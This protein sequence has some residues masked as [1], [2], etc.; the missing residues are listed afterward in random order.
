MLVIDKYYIYSM[1]E[2]NR[3]E[4]SKIRE[5]IIRLRNRE[6]SLLASDYIRRGIIACCVV[7]MF[8]RCIIIENNKHSS[9]KNN[10]Q[11]SN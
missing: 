3:E 5:E 6:L 4:N 2:I 9:R 8:C 10:N 7:D 11:Y 1:D